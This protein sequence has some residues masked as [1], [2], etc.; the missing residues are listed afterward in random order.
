MFRRL[1]PRGSVSTT[2]AKAPMPASANSEAT[3][4]VMQGAVGLLLT[5]V[6]FSEVFL[7]R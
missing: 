2:G 7:R 3:T 5:A 6:A 1:R 4:R